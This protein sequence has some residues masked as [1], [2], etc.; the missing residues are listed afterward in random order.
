MKRHLQPLYSFLGSYR[1]TNAF[2]IGA[3]AQS[4]LGEL[5]A[6]RPDF[7]SAGKEFCRYRQ[8]LFVLSVTPAH[9][10]QVVVFLVH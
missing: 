8:F 10:V 3:L 1:I 7:L 6:L 5:L 2:E 9:F 4:P